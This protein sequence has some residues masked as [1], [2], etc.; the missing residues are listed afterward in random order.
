MEQNTYGIKTLPAGTTAATVDWSAI[1][2]AAVKHYFWYE[3][4]TPTVTARLVYVD[5]EGFLLH[6][7]CAERQPK[8][9]Y[10]AYM[11]DIYKDSCMEFFADWL[12]DGRYI[13]ME[14]N[15]NGALLSCIGPDRYARTP[16]KE[17]SGGAIF[18]VVAEVGADMWSVTATIPLTLLAS[19]LG[20]DTLSVTSGFTFRGNFYKC[21]DETAVIH[22]GMWNP[23]GTEKADFHRPEYFGT[24]VVE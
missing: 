24:L 23:I 20:V 15:A 16:I 1:P 5:G 8:A 18:P 21:G 7:E 14:M 9:V 2:A 3:G 22:F 13:N 11:E 10:T 17:L 4:Y 12:G 6:M 19:I